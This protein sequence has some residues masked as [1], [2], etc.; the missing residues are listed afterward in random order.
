M[1]E[2]ALSVNF[3]LYRFTLIDKCSINVHPDP[4]RSMFSISLCSRFKI[5][6]HKN[7][8]FVQTEME[9]LQLVSVFFSF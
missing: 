3:L 2:D 6:I 5:D 4:P 8:M 7:S 1:T 9:G